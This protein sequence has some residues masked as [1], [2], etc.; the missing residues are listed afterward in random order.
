MRIC[1]VLGAILVVGV[2]HG[3]ACAIQGTDSGECMSRDLF[4]FQMPFCQDVVRYVACVPRYQPLYPN[5][6]LLAKDAWVKATHERVVQERLTQEGNSTLRA[7]GMNEFGIPGIVQERFTD[8]EDCVNAYKNFLCWLNFPRCDDEGRS[9]ILC[10][11]V[12]ENYFRSCRYPEEMWRCYEPRFYGGKAPEEDKDLDADGLPIYWRAQFIGQPFR[13]NLFD[14]SNDP[15]AVCTPSLKNSASV[16]AV[17][18]TV[19]LALLVAVLAL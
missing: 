9:L 10:T 5:H 7:L 17:A 13:S 15:L 11:S 1:I 12:C 14:T 16:P 18:T 8:N 6:T 3:A 19:A 4:E 2:E